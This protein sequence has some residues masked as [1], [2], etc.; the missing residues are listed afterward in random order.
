MAFI[1]EPIISCNNGTITKYCTLYKEQVNVV[2]CWD[3]KHMTIY[4]CAIEK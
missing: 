3:C 2:N 4:G 1:D